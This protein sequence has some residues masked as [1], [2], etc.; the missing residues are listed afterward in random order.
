MQYAEDENGCSCIVN[1]RFFRT[2]ENLVVKNLGNGKDQDP[3]NP[4]GGFQLTI[5]VL[6]TNEEHCKELKKL[7]EN[8]VANPGKKPNIIPQIEWLEEKV[9]EKKEYGVEIKKG[10][11]VAGDV[12]Y[13]PTRKESPENHEVSLSQ[14]TLILGWLHSH[15][16]NGYGMFSYQDLRFFRNGYR[17]ISDSRKPEAFTIIVCRDKTDPT[18]TNVYALKIDSFNIFSQKVDAVWNS[19]KYIDFNDEKERLEKI[20][21]EQ[22]E[23][24]H[25]YEGDLEF[26]FLSQFEGFG[27][28]LYKASDNLDNWIK[29][30]LQPEPGFMP[31]FSVKQTP[32]N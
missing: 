12:V 19:L 16:I 3:L 23:K 27:I 25:Y 31:P 6:P 15:P 28:S 4:C 1:P 22:A 9:D 13:T 21:L 11:N 17:E 29:L 32:C 5:G 7:Y 20:H 14:H 18:K 8:D 26:S 30:E 2:G 24:Y 10:M